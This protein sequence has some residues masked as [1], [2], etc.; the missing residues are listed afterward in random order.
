M[1]LGHIYLIDGNEDKALFL[2]KKAIELASSK[3]KFLVGF[4]EDFQ[5]LMQY[6][7]DK[8]TYLI[9]RDQLTL[10]D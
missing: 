8:V 9:V 2:Y 10:E 1:N 3:K 5:Y 4:D 7:L 6:G